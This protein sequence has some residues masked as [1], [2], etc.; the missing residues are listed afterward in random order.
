[1]P[2]K[3]SQSQKFIYC[4]ISFRKHSQNDKIVEMENSDCQGLAKGV[5][6]GN[7]VTT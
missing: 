6:G 3:K 5:E 2:S 4:I 1:M 7:D